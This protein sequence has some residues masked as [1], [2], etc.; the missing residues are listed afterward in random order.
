MYDH[1]QAGRRDVTSR[2]VV[3]RPHLIV[4]AR[5][6]ELGRILAIRPWFDELF[7]LF[8][9]GKIQSMHAVM[10]T[11]WTARDSGHL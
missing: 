5:I 7:C 11:S 1:L 10:V 8:R 4:Y 6:C 2:L 3:V 9:N